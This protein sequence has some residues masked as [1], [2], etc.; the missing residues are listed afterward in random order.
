MWSVRIVNISLRVFRLSS[1]LLVVFLAACSDEPAV[2]QSNQAASQNSKRASADSAFDQLQAIDERDI[3]QREGEPKTE[4]AIESPS[5]A[6]QID[7]ESLDTVSNELQDDDDAY[8]EPS[9]IVTFSSEES[10][11]VIR[12]EAP[13]GVN[14]SNAQVTISGNGGDR[15]TRSFSAGEAIE[16][17]GELPDGVYKWET[18]ITPEVD[19]SV[20]DQMRAVRESGDFQAEKELA[21]RL[22]AEGSLPTRKQAQK[23]RQSGAFIV[24]GGIVRPSLVDDPNSDSGNGG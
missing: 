7:E 5:V 6:D 13:E 19:E 14:Y 11:G 21:A 10:S 9:S 15:T 3:S 12:W 22:R 24:Q 1:L 17:Y 8:Y 23:N 18:V 20:R 4:I 2:E 16:L